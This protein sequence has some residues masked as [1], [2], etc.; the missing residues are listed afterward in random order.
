M[1][2]VHLGTLGSKRQRNLALKQTRDN[3]SRLR[4][5]AAQG[6]WDSLSFCFSKQT[7][8]NV[9]KSASPRTNCIVQCVQWPQ[10]RAGFFRL[11]ASTHGF[12]SIFLFIFFTCGT[13]PLRRKQL[14]QLTAR[15]QDVVPGVLDTITE[16]LSMGKPLPIFVS[17][18]MISSPLWG[19]CDLTS[20]G[21]E[22]GFV[23]WPGAPVIPE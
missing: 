15:I 16:K 11:Y 19:V 21:S 14:P 18:R 13:T 12:I 5:C 20:C 9:N 3:Q 10:K 23:C 22:G 7:R 1:Y 8:N 4:L 17:N 2:S 6:S